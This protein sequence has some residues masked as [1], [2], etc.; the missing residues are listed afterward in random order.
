MA[1]FRSALNTTWVT[2]VRSRKSTKSRLP[3]SRR[4]F[5]HP[6]K[7]AFLPASETRNVPHMCVRF[8]SPK[9]SSKSESLQKEFRRCCRTHDYKR[10]LRQLTSC[11]SRLKPRERRKLFYLCPSS[12]PDSSFRIYYK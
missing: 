3:W 2:P 12:Y 11:P 5:T 1:E 4:L 8:K 9:K 7:T 10:F 6:I